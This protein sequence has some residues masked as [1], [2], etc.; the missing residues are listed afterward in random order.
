MGKKPFYLTCPKCGHPRFV[1]PIVKSY[2]CKSCGVQ[3][4]VRNQGSYL[5]ETVLLAPV[6]LL[7]YWSVAAALQSHG[8]DREA[9]QGWGI[10]AA[11]LISLPIYAALRPYLVG[12]ECADPK[13]TNIAESK[14]DQIGKN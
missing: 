5:I 8:L 1:I 4:Q 7:I 13:D 3:V 2:Q 11:F 14:E 9:S 10:F 12:L 6:S